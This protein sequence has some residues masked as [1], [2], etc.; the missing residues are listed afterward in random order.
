VL[1]GRSALLTCILFAAIVGCGDSG[2][3]SGG[4]N[5]NMAISF[6]SASHKTVIVGQLTDFDLTIDN[7]GK[8]DIPKLGIMFDDGDR[9]LD[10][11]T[12][13]SSGSCAVDKALPGLS[14]GALTQGK[15]LK[16]TMT[17][18]PRSAGNFTFKFHIANGG[19]YL[20]EADGKGYTYNWQ[21]TILT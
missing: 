10:H 8:A 7:V 11:Y 1:L 15:E 14:C 18:Q 19:L 12:V 3:A 2:G 21:Q 5:S 4:D 20:N 16:F 9:F 6:D 13:V 17:A